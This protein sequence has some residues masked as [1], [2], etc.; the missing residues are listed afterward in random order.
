MREELFQTFLK[1][2]FGHSNFTLTPLQQSG[3]ARQNL[4]VDT[5]DKKYILTYNEK[6]D[7]NE[8]FFY[9]TEIF[10]DFELNVP[11]IYA[12]NPERTLYLQEF[13]GINT[14]SEIITEE[15]HSERVKQLVAKTIEML[16]SF[17]QKT[18]GKIDFS[19]AY[20]Y[21][22]YDKL[23]I[24]HDLYYF[25]N[26]LIDVLEIDYHKG[27]LLKEFHHISDKV[28]SLQPQTVMMRDFQARN[29]MVNDNDEIYFIDYQAAMSGP[30]TYDLVSFLF[31]AKAKF[32]AEWKEEFLA[33]YFL[34]N[35]QNFSAESYPE[36][37]N[38]CKL[39]RFLQVLGAYGF[40]GLIQRKKH[41]IESIVQGIKN[42]NELKAEWPE[43][44]KYPELSKII[45]DLESEHTQSKV[46]KLI[47]GQ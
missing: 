14:L 21:E 20:E 40:R 1:N 4:R 13:V 8:C 25:K 12:I 45:S 47:N 42:I 37:V 44:I 35:Q 34:L 6:I 23:P 16:S 24:I 10:H 22:A 7:E 26:F 30:A 2:Y 46:N 11:H 18:S 19:K 32:P 29:I 9:F 41:F 3:S 33:K 38:Y 17:Q 43:L 36:A 31:Q 5:A 15:G 27:K 28:K 39:M